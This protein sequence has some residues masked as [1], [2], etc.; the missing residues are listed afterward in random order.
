[1]MW[2]PF[3]LYRTLDAHNTGEAEPHIEEQDYLKATRGF[4]DNTVGIAAIGLRMDPKS[5]QNI[6]EDIQS[7]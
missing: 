6:L 1:M 7:N 3:G 4:Y 2:I 5:T